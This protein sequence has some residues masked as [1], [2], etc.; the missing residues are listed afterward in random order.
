[1]RQVQELEER[2]FK[3]GAAQALVDRVFSN[4]NVLDRGSAR[5][6]HGGEAVRCVF[7]GLSRRRFCDGVL[8]LQ[9][10]QRD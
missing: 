8:R 9:A 4:N 6:F 3:S 7:D 5:H 1:M 10:A 2:P